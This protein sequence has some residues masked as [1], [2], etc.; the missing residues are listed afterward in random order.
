MGAAIQFLESHG[1]VA[2]ELQDDRI[3]VGPVAVL[4]DE[5]RAWIRAHKLELLKELREHQKVPKE[6]VIETVSSHVW[7]A[8]IDGHRVRVIDKER[9]TK[10]EFVDSMRKQ[11]GSARVGVCVR[12]WPPENMA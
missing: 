7:S 3:E 2:V 12:L 6:H 10:P 11:F 5:L 9:Q 4:N 8:Q 1:L